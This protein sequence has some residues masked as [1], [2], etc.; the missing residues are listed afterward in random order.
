MSTLLASQLGPNFANPETVEIFFEQK[1]LRTIQ[2][3]FE[4]REQ[5]APGVPGK[6]CETNLFFGFFFDGTKNNYI[7][8]ETAKNHSNVARLYDCYPGLSVPGV[9]PKATDWQYNA[10]RYTHFFKVYVPGVASPFPQ[11]GD[12]GK[13]HQLTRGAA[14]GAIGEHRIIWA[15]VQAINNLHRYFCKTPLVG[16]DEMD[17]LIRDVTLNKIA[18]RTMEDMEWRKASGPGADGLF[19]TRCEFENLLL[20]LHSAVSKHWPD[21]KTGRAAKIDPAIVKTVFISIFGF[22]RGA[23]QARAFTNWLQSLCRLDARLCGKPGQMTLGGFNVQFDFLG[24]FDTVASVGLGNTFG[25]SVMA[26]FLDG[27]QAWADAEESLRIPPD[28]RCL[29]LVAAHELRR[30]FPVD[31]ISVKGQLQERC[32]EVVVPGVHSDI[33][34]GYCPG[35]QGRGVDPNGNDML[36][37]V[38]LLM[39]YKAARLNGVPLK[40]EL[41]NPPA[42]ARFALASSTIKAFNA[43]IASCTEVSGPI[44]RIMREQARKQMEWRVARRVV[45]TAPLQTSASFLR[46]SAFD[47]NDL[48]SA[49]KEFEREIDLFLAWVRGKGN[50]FRA[51]AQRPGF[52]N[53]HAAEWE[54]IARWWGEEATPNKAVLEFF[55]NYVHD[56]RAWFKLSTT[57]PDNER[58]M[59]AKLKLWAFMRKRARKSDEMLAQVDDLGRPVS[60][61]WA[62]T[63][64]TCDQQRAVDEYEKNGKIPRMFTEGRE[65][66]DSTLGTLGM[67]GRAGYLRFRKI[68]SGSD[69]DLIS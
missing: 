25:N 52:G 55:D 46:A 4:P 13:G 28:I 11:V 57:S 36:A 1:E 9:L 27:H 41:A 50:Q 67:S 7:L 37:R 29:H 69:S 32:E 63:A 51:S 30:S 40:L 65:P 47:Q 26:K 56:S 62:T 43:Y 8:A 31:S 68:Y 42:K 60:H 15:L 24:L 3:Q 39:M 38:P 6:S 64:L 19:K 45:G 14:A 20:R 66:F 49:G 21:K 33:G 5:S 34:S 59:L 10:A 61:G 17:R 35:E 53:D 18:R 58:D 22:S 12:D 23:T 16:Q 48:Y 2:K 44:H 54:E